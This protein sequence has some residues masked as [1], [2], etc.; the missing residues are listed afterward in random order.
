MLTRKHYVEISRAVRARHFASR[1]ERL[2]H[3]AELVATLQCTND[4]FD[5]ERFIAACMKEE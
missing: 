2:D 3:A 1:K 4:N 5:G